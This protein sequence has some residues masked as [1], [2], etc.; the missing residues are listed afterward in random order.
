VIGI[1]EAS[2]EKEEEEEEEEEA[3]TDTKKDESPRRC[4]V[5]KVNCR[6]G[7]LLSRAH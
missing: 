7:I 6:G 1:E 4:N 3:R 2:K 5:Q